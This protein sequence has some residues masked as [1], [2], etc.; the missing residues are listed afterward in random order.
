MWKWAHYTAPQDSE[1]LNFKKQLT[2]TVYSYEV[3][4]SIKHHSHHLSFTQQ[5]LT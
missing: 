1:P 2:E 3:M 4:V 5:E